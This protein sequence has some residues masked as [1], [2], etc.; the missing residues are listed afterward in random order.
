MLPP[1]PRGRGLGLREALLLW[2]R[3]SAIAHG[4]REPGLC[5]SHARRSPASAS[6]SSSPGDGPDHDGTVL[7]PQDRRLPWSPK[8]DSLPGGA[9]HTLRLHAF[10][11]GLHRQREA[12][13]RLGSGEWAGLGSQVQ[14]RL[15]GG[16]RGPCLLPRPPHCRPVLDRGARAQHVRRAEASPGLADRPGG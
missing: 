12:T 11:R 16:A 5:W 10:P 4:S 9:G 2:P 13:Q 14:A 7:T 6:V 8:T 15:A 3:F 1:C